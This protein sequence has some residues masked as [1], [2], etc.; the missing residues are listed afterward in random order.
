MNHIK[1]IG[2]L[3]LMVVSP[4][5]FFVVGSILI[6]AVIALLGA[7]SGYNSYGECF[8]GAVMSTPMIFTMFIV[9]VIAIISYT[10]DNDQ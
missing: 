6:S 4:F 1:N 2:K 10:V 8:R 3:L 9:T 5:V 7:L